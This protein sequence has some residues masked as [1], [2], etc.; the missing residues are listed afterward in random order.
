MIVESSKCGSSE[1]NN[2]GRVCE[3]CGTGAVLQSQTQA[4]GPWGSPHG[5]WLGANFGAIAMLCKGMKPL[6]A[7]PIDAWPLGCHSYSFWTSHLK[8]SCSASMHRVQMTVIPGMNQAF[9]RKSYVEV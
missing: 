2:R 4:G 8:L 7:V 5:L 3:V 9:D 6:A 1:L